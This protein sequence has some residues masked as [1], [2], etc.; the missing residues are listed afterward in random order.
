[1]NA[2]WNA[3]PT[4]S[5]A[6]PLS[7]MLVALASLV[8]TPAHADLTDIVFATTLENAAAAANQAVFD[9]L[10][11]D[12]GPRAGPLPACPADT[13]AVF[14]NVRELVHTSNELIG[15]GPTEFSLGLDVQGLGFALRWTAAEELAAQ[16]SMSTEFANSQLS[17]LAS[18]LSALRFG[19]RGFRIAGL[20][21]KRGDR[22]VVYAD[23]KSRRGG[24]AS[25]DEQLADDQFE[26]EYSRLGWFMNGSFGFGD[27]DPT[28]QEDA[29]DFD[30]TEITAGVD[31]RFT[32]AWVLG[33]IAGYSE[34]VVD[35]DSAL[36]IVDGGIEADGFSGLVFGLFQSERYYLSGSLGYQS[37]SFDITRN[38]KYPSFNPNIPSVNETA[39]STTDSG[40]I[41]ATA[42]AGVTLQKGAF[43][44]EPYFRSEYIDID[45]DPFREM[46]PNPVNPRNFDF[47]VGR[48]K[49]QSWDNT[50]GMRFQYALTPPFGVFIPFLAGEYHREIEDDQ[51]RISAVYLNLPDQLRTAGFAGN[52]NLLTDP[53]D[54]SYY[55]MKIGMST[56]LRGARQLEDEG[57]VK[58]G[59]QGFVQYQKVLQLENYSDNVFTA[60]LRLEF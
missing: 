26:D 7:L 58:G 45:M 46:N 9:A 52:F 23:N 49:I 33:G 38:I 12:C 32:D 57:V 3:N 13:F 53:P 30:G 10:A 51:R 2:R 25:A 54:D 16:G 50:L 19:A 48:Q 4:G 5:R 28:Q 27:K 17:N 35:F 60:G 40:T 18:R 37:Q 36:S 1:M 44:F 22:R 59:I 34:S 31:Y 20:P 8:A 24:G 15:F 6:R 42:D 14:R 11:A 39:L 41:T 55:V 43:A 47:E 29:F 56:I 21:G